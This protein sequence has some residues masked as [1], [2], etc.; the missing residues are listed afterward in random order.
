MDKTSTTWVSGIPKQNSVDHFVAIG[1]LGTGVIFIA[2]KIYVVYEL[3]IFLAAI[4]ILFLLGTSVLASLILIQ[5]LTC[6]SW[7]RISK[8]KPAATPS[9]EPRLI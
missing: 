6:W 4:G 2:T 5:A 8:L 9:V 7:R 1:L 3:L